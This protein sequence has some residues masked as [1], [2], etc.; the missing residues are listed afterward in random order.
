MTAKT[1]AERA[2]AELTY[3]IAMMGDDNRR[4]LLRQLVTDIVAADDYY[5]PA[6]EGAYSLTMT[7]LGDI[8]PYGLNPYHERRELA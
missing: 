1:V 5:G 4:A 6:D 3:R 7:L 2:E 8:K